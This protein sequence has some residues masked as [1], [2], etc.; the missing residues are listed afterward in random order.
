V[1][2]VYVH[3]T[4]EA[5][6]KRLVIAVIVVMAVVLAVRFVSKENVDLVNGISPRSNSLS[7]IKVTMQELASLPADQRRAVLQRDWPNLEESVAYYARQNKLIPQGAK[8]QRIEFLFGS[9]DKIQANDGAGVIHTGYAKDQLVARMHVEGLAK[10]VDLFVQC[11]N[12]MITDTYSFTNL[13][14]LMTLVPREQFTIAKGEGLV[15]HVPF[16]V[17][18]ELAKQHRLPLYRGKTM[19]AAREVLPEVARGMEANTD[20]VQVTVKVN[21]GDHFDL[22]AGVYTPAAQRRGR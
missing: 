19:V 10:P 6:M 21:E 1:V 11:L 9:M 13:A 17:A 4:K 7:K 15:S 14:P 12:G 18:V 3:V 5:R 8:V 20:N 22:V 2:L 16:Q